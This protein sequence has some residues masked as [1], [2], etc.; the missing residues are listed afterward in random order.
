MKLLHY[1]MENWILLQY[2]RRE[3]LASGGA[4]YKKRRG[5][6]LQTRAAGISHRRGS[7][8]AC[9]REML[10]NRQ[11]LRPRSKA[12]GALRNPPKKSLIQRRG[13][14]LHPD[15]FHRSEPATPVPIRVP[16]PFH[17][18][19]FR[20]S[21]RCKPPPAPAPRSNRPP[22]ARSWPW[23][24]SRSGI[25]RL[26]KSPRARVA[27]AVALYFGYRDALNADICH[28][29]PDLVQL[30]RFDDGGDQLHAFVPAFIGKSDRPHRP[31]RVVLIPNIAVS[32]PRSDGRRIK[33]LHDEERKRRTELA[34]GDPDCALPGCGTLVG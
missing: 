8:L 13:V 6:L 23:A 10:L 29:L 14:K 34:R 27:D 30:E 17:R 18:L 11:K 1:S 19:R 12:G 15:R 31:F 9:R 5:P 4:W 3:R 32:V 16:K 25:Q 21:R 20:S 28:R 33:E 24:E 22:P 2:K 26:D 7:W